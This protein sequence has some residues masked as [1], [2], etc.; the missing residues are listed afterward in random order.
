[1]MLPCIYLLFLVITDTYN[2]VYLR[3][4]VIKKKKNSSKINLLFIVNLSKVFKH[5]FLFSY[6]GNYLFHMNIYEYLFHI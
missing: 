3:K 6:F 5:S 2:V 1:M 4:Q